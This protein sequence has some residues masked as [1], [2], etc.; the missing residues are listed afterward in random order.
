VQQQKVK[1]SKA[2][3]TESLPLPP[4]PADPPSSI[5]VCLKDQGVLV[6]GVSFVDAVANGC[7]DIRMRKK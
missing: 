4:F 6:C 1:G 7:I 2:N 5:C 3:V